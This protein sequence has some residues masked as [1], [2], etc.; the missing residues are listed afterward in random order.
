M[1]TWLNVKNNSESTLS[2][3]ITAAATSLTLVTGEGAKFPSTNFNISIDDE[4]LTCSSRTNDV[5]TVTR[6]QEG[7]TAAIHTTGATVSLNVTAAVIDQIQ[8]AIDDVTVDVDDT[9]VNGHTTTPIS[10][11]WA[12]D[13][14]ADADAHYTHGTMAGETAT[15][16]LKIADID[17]TPVDSETAA[18]ISSNWAFDHVAAADPHTGYVLESSEDASDYGFVLDEDD[19][20]SDSA[21]KIPTQQSVKAYVDDNAGGFTGFD[22]EE[23]TD[24]NNT[25]IGF[26]LGGI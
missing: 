18:P 20:V 12:Y 5:L 19:M 7:T 4:I 16:Y 25:V 6:H 8:D 17:D 13:H 1:T 15:D 9:P 2:A 10:S 3:D 23:V 26:D 21:T 14:A 11:N 22:G 24:D